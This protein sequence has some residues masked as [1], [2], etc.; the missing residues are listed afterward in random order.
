M[1]WLLSTVAGVLVVASMACRAIA[2]APNQVTSTPVAYSWRRLAD[3]EPE[4]SFDLG[5]GRHLLAWTFHQL[6]SE[7]EPATS[8]LLVVERDAD[9]TFGFALTSSSRLDGAITLEQIE[10]L[11][12][13]ATD[14]AR[15]RELADRIWPPDAE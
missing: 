2:P 13:P 8:Q 15:R 4:Q 12:A 7:A 10:E 6:W 1:R 3:R 14:L 5:D 11:L 9:G